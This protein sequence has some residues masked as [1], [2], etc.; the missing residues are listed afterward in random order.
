MTTPQ[1]T[2]RLR[3]TTIDGLEAFDYYDNRVLG[4]VGKKMT[5]AAVDG[6]WEIARDHAALCRAEKRPFLLLYEA[7]RITLS[8]YARQVATDTIKTFADMEG[9]IAGVFN[10]HNPLVMVI[11]SFILREMSHSLPN[12]VVQELPSRTAALNWLTSFLD[13]PTLRE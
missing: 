9:A 7:E 4:L 2:P 10:R 6:F 3:E 5:R 13:D 11:R 8:P 12:F 1:H